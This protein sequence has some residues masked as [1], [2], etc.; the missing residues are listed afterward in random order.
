[1]AKKLKVGQSVTWPLQSNQVQGVIREVKGG[2][3][4][5]VEAQREVGSP[6]YMG[7]RYVVQARHIQTEAQS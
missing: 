7:F 2:G 5:V 6:S 1:M 4:Y 3:W